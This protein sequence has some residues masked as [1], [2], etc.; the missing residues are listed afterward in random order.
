MPAVSIRRLA[1]GL[2]LLP[3]LLAAQPSAPAAPPRPAPNPVWLEQQLRESVVLRQH[4]VGVSVVDVETGQQLFGLN[5]ARYFTPASTMKL[6][7]LYAGLTLLPDSLPSLHYVLRPDT[8][9]FW[10]T[11][12]PTLLHGDVPSRRAYEFLKNRPEKLF[13]A[14]VPAPPAFGPGWSWDDYGYYFQPERGPLP[15]YG[16]TVRFYGGTGAPRVLPAFFRPLTFPTPAGLPNPAHD[17]VRRPPEEN[18][19]LVFPAARSWVDEVPFRTSPGLLLQLLQDTLRRPV[20]LAGPLR[21]TARD[22]VRTLRGLPADSLYRRMIRVSDN[23]LA[24]Q[25]LL[26]CS[27]ALGADSLSP[28]RAIRAMRGNYLRTLPDA[29]VWVDGSGLSRLN[30]LTPRSLTAVLL[31]LHQRVPE[32][33]LLSLLAAGGGPGTLRRAYV[34]GKTGPWLWGK[35]GTLTNTHNLAGYLRT[36]SGRLVAFSFF[37][38]GYVVPTS[39]IRREMERVLT[40]VRD[41]L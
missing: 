13:Y 3:F 21:L 19:F 26:M 24:E 35:T 15:I 8:L 34:G 11:G 2:A 20:L 36:R 30:L 38:N 10:G 29:P 25:L 4:Q 7:S 31:L 18:R 22:S 23:F 27:S 32:P 6:L 37:N 28:A 41:R 39:D 12:D 17:H 14:Q 5:E 40:L 9:L 1:L 33:R 16:N